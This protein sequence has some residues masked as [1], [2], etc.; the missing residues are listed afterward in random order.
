MNEGL[1]LQYSA[2]NVDHNVCSIDGYGTFHEMGIISM[3]NPA[4]KRSLVIPI[5]K[6]TS[7]DIVN[8]GRIPI[9]N[10][11]QSS[12]SILFFGRRS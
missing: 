2:D 9:Q 1:F 11:Y 4:E 6:I 10:F 8:V 12:D 3:T 5:I 7:N